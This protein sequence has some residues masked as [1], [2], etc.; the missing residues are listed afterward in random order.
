MKSEVHTSPTAY[1]KQGIQQNGH[2]RSF[3]TCK[4]LFT[5]LKSRSACFPTL[6]GCSARYA[7]YI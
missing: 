3:L 6:G 2:M 1:L 7:E 5:E 4:V